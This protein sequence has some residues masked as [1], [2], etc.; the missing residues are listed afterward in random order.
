MGRMRKDTDHWNLR[1]EDLPPGHFVRREPLLAGAPDNPLFRLIVFRRHKADRLKISI[2]GYLVFALAGA[3]IATLGALTW[4]MA[5]WLI[6]TWAILSMEISDRPGWVTQRRGGVAGLTALPRRPVED[7]HLAAYDPR[8]MAVA[9]WASTLSRNL[10]ILW[11]SLFLV[12][13][14]T[15]WGRMIDIVRDDAIQPSSWLWT[16]PLAYMCFRV[17]LRFLTPYHTL[18]HCVTML[19]YARVQ[20]WRRHRPWK[21]FVQST[22]TLTRHFL[23]FAV[24][25]ILAVAVGLQFASLYQ[26]LPFDMNRPSNLLWG[27]AIAMLAGAVIALAAAPMLSRNRDRY[28]ERSAELIAWL[29][30]QE[31][32]VAAGEG[33]HKED[34]GGGRDRRRAARLR[35]NDQN[36]MT[37]LRKS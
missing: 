30:E 1:E 18:P 27:G 20:W 22:I 7:L 29:L 31:R 33:A 4:P 19:E 17:T 11:G 14:G 3:T 6:A 16:A 25:L 8:S 26:W 5:A 36:A 35:L 32:A 9:L 13:V 37:S 23:V 2:F 12:G 21:Y 10:M 34:K 24:L 28:L 15:C